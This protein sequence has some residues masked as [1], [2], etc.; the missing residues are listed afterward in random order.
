MKEIEPNFKVSETSLFAELVKDKSKR[1]LVLK[2]LAI[3]KQ[4]QQETAETAEETAASANAAVKK[5]YY[6]TVAPSSVVCV[7]DI[8]KEIPLPP[9]IPSSFSSFLSATPMAS[10]LSQSEKSGGD[11]AA[12]AE[13]H[14]KE[15]H[16]PLEEIPVPSGTAPTD[17]VKTGAKKSVYNGRVP[18]GVN[19]VVGADSA[20]GMWFSVYS[21][22]H[23]R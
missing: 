10:Q 7:T 5:E 14:K 20:A 6:G 8:I 2:N 23:L 21:E 17:G 19:G 11:V 18:N 16:V 13:S 12:A 1:E 22:G 3:K 4:Q 15:H 9:Q